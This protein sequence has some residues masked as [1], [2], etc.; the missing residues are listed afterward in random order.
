MIILPWSVNKLAEVGVQVV[1]LELCA[2]HYYYS[3]GGP[4][5]WQKVVASS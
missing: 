3:T 1:T 4:F 5:N 2:I